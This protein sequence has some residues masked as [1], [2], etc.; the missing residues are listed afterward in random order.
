MNQ[1]KYTN[2]NNKHHFSTCHFT[3]LFTPPPHFPPPSHISA[4]SHTLSILDEK[5]S[6]PHGAV[7]TTFSLINH[8]P[9]FTFLDHLLQMICT[10]REKVKEL[11]HHF[12]VAN[13]SKWRLSYIPPPYTITPTG[14][15]LMNEIKT[16]LHRLGKVLV[17]SQRAQKIDHFHSHQ[18]TLFNSSSTHNNPP[19]QS[20]FPPP[21]PLPASTHPH[22]PPQFNIHHIQ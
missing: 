18:N 19:P 1:F 22:S 8:L 17:P 20:K 12:Q 11:D 15:Q 2:N 4:H 13:N 5:I 9:F 6:L 16:Y 14:L 10:Q 21:S 3:C 7:T